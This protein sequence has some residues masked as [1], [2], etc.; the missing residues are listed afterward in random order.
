MSLKTF[1]LKTCLNCKIN[2][3]GDFLNFLA[4]RASIFDCPGTR[5]S[6]PVTPC[7]FVPGFGISEDSVVL[8]SRSE[9]NWGVNCLS[10]NT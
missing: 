8:F 9:F 2:H 5:C 6:L 1:Y 7:P 10:K 3:S 4:P